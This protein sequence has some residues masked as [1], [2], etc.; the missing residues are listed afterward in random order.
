LTLYRSITAE[1]TGSIPVTPT[2]TN[3]FLGPCGDAGCQQV[4]AVA[5]WDSKPPPGSS[6]DPVRGG[7]GLRPASARA[8]RDRLSP[9]P[10]AAFRCRADLAR[11]TPCPTASSRPQRPRPTSACLTASV[12]RPGGPLWPRRTGLESVQGLLP[13]GERLE[14]KGGAAR[15]LFVEECRA[16]QL[17]ALGNRA[18]LE[19]VAPATRPPTMLR[20]T[21]RHKQE[22]VSTARPMASTA[23]DS[24]R[25]P[26]QEGDQ[27]Q[28]ARGW[29]S[30]RVG[31][32]PC[33]GA[34][35]TRP[36]QPLGEWSGRVSGRALRAI[37]ATACPRRAPGRRRCPSAIA[38]LLERALLD[39]A[40]S[41][42]RT[43]WAFAGN[44]GDTD[45][46]RR[47]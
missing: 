47:R 22:H 21:R 10:T 4:G 11:T 42:G 34:D 14:D 31:W 28:P 36:L 38:T 45:P 19:D 1:V 30:D 32:E 5:R 37:D 13:R 24:L 12:G 26:E 20:V 43:A 17:I 25:E 3:A 18:V 33:H 35:P 27:D 40:G 39:R 46:H 44:S 8:C 16:L 6:D 9:T 29:T 7:K 23:D 2:S 15:L 41:S